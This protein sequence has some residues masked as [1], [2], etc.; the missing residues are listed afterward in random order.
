[1]FWMSLSILIPIAL[2]IYMGLKHRKHVVWFEHLW[3]YGYSGLIIL[4]FYLISNFAMNWHR[5]YIGSYIKELQDYEYWNE[6]ISQ[7]CTETYACG[8]DSEGNTKYCEKTYD[9]SYVENHWQYYS[10]KTNTGISINLNESEYKHVLAKLGGERIFVDMRRNYHTTDGDMYKTVFDSGDEYAPVTTTSLY[11][12]KIKSSDL[13]VFNLK[14]VTKE[15]F[16]KYGLYDYPRLRS[17]IF[18]PSLIGS[19]LPLSNKELKE[20]NGVYGN[21]LQI[22]ISFWIYKNKTLQSGIYQEY[23]FV[24]GNKNEVNVCIGINDDE[25]IEWVHPFTW[26]LTLNTAKIRQDILS[27]NHLSDTLLSDYIKT[28]FKTDLQNNFIRREFSQFDYIQVKTPIWLIIIFIILQLAGNI[29]LSYVAINNR[30][31]K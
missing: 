12:N 28:G 18:Y 21:D 27:L 1:M 22:K 6:Y 19:N 29:F 30:I 14:K 10:A 26:S 20:I 11:V 13:T 9:C 8:T 17:K 25:K 7:T 31:Y 15:E 23:F 24:G 4:I 5:E 3:L 16:K 2:S